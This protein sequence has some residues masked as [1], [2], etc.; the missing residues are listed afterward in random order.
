MIKAR[1]REEAEPFVEEADRAK[2]P[3]VIVPEPEHEHE[4]PELEDELEISD[5]LI[6]IRILRD[7]LTTLAEAYDNA[8][9]GS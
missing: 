9:Q 4:E 3:A 2:Q 8:E 1:E 5:D 6:E 7:A